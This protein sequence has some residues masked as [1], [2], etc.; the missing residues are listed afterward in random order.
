M[1]RE[2]KIKRIKGIIK[3]WGCVSNFDVG[4]ESSSPCLFGL[5]DVVHLV[6]NFN[7]DDVT[8]FTYHKDYELSNTDV[9]Y[10]EL[11]DDVLDEVFEIISD[12]GLDMEETFEKTKN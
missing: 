12:Y 2:E 3:E 4:V 11:S 9:P 7:Q 8:V 10:E 6:E 1:K 5:N